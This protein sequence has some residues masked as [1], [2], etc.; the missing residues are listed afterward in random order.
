M[1]T[2]TTR[3]APVFALLFSKKHFCPAFSKK[4]FCPA[5]F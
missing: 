4:H 1:S 3:F 5:F 2:F